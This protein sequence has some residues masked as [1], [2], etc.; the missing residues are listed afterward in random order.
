M[1][2]TTSRT[3]AG[4]ST[5]AEVETSPATWTSPVVTR[6]STATRPFGSAA[7]IASRMLSEIWSQ[8]LSGCPSVTDSDVNRRSSVIMLQIGRVP[9]PVCPRER[10]EPPTRASER[11]RSL[12]DVAQAQLVFVDLVH[13]DGQRLVFDS[14]VDE[15]ADVVEEVALVQVGVIVVD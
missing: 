7:R 11:H 8:I 9:A 2:L 3:I 5:Y 12:L 6:V 13:R 10:T 4:I 1:R 15:R 14:G